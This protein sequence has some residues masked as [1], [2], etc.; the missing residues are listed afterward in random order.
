MSLPRPSLVYSRPGQPGAAAG[1][2]SCPNRLDPVR[3]PAP[4]AGRGRSAQ[5]ARRCFGAVDA[6]HLKRSM[7]ALWGRYVRQTFASREAVAAHF[8]VAF[9]T[10][11]NW[12]DELHAP[13]AAVYAK[14]SIEDGAGLALVMAQAVDR[15][16]AVGRPGA[17]S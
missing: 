4:G 11:C 5:A 16:G 9:Q 14:A 13:S 10:A 6:Y 7:P 12:W 8:G 15:A 1:Q 2:K 17:G 3:G